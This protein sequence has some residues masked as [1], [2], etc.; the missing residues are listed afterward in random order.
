MSMTPRVSLLHICI[1][2]IVQG[3]T[4]TTKLLKENV[5]II[6]YGVNIGEKRF[7]ICESFL[8]SPKT[9]LFM[10]KKQ[11]CKQARIY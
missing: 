2:G 11:C 7:Q 10:K 6:K 1:V 5:N 4:T 3:A 8:I 9:A